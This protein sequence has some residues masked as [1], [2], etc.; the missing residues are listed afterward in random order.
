MCRHRLSRRPHQQTLFA[1]IL[2]S[3][4]RSS[5]SRRSFARPRSN[6]N[7]AKHQT[8]APTQS[9]C[10]AFCTKSRKPTACELLRLRP[11]FADR[12][13][14]TSVCEASLAE[15]PHAAASHRPLSGPLI[16]TILL[17]EGRRPIA[18]LFRCGRCRCAL[19]ALAI[20]RRRNE[21]QSPAASAGHRAPRW[22]ADPARTRHC[23]VAAVHR[24]PQ[25]KR[26]EARQKCRAF[27]A[28]ASSLWN[29]TSGDG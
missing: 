11:S 16:G 12:T 25:V 6:E 17:V 20:D 4:G 2:L 7:R 5:A 14:T 13:P 3:S 28:Q 24:Q 1:F 26:D 9:D 19:N 10:G 18:S 15:M 21:R 22:A 29:S 27:L 8:A 23:V